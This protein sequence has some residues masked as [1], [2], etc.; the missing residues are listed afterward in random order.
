MK[1]R[2]S[3]SRASPD[4]ECGDGHRFVSPE[5]DSARLAAQTRLGLTRLRLPL[6]K[7]AWVSFIARSTRSSGDRS[8]LNSCLPT[9]PMLAARQR[10]RREAQAAS[11]LN[12]P[13]ILT[14]HDIGE[15][16]GREY[17]VT[18]FVD[19]GTLREGMR[20]MRREPGG[21]SLTCSSASP[22]AW[23]RPIKPG[24]FTATSSLTTSSSQSMATPSWPTSA[25]PSSSKPPIAEAATRVVTAG[26][27]RVGAIVGT[28][29]YMSPEQATGRPVDARSDVFSLGVVLYQLLSGRQ[30]FAGATELEILQKHPASH[31]G[32]A[33]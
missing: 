11:S 10:F 23:P 32:A 13:H 4:I 17:L 30:P 1:S 24:L 27:T 7:G 28:F 29:A 5:P 19:G 25:W 16:E 6:A 18:E 12:H 14:V 2:K 26:H 15:Y 3:S 22:M 9:S 21:K 8:R 33:R 31:C 20:R